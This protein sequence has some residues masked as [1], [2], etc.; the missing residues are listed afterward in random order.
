[1]QELL[2]PSPS[3]TQ[4][5]DANWENLGNKAQLSAEI[6]DATHIRVDVLNAGRRVTECSIAGRMS[7]AAERKVGREEDMAYSLLGLFDIN[8]PMIYG[9]RK[10]KPFL[11]LQRAIIEALNAWRL[12]RRSH[13]WLQHM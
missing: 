10:E 8:M 4:F 11:R 6:R 1:M 12:A 13:G 7:W 3:R 9:E 5:Y 2:A